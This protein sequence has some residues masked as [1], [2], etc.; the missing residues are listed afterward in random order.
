MNGNQ[1]D[2]QNVVVFVESSVINGKFIQGYDKKYDRI[3]SK[4]NDLDS[5]DHLPKSIIPPNS[6]VL[7]KISVFDGWNLYVKEIKVRFGK[8]LWEQV[9]ETMFWDKP[10]KTLSVKEWAAAISINLTLLTLFYIIATISLYLF[11][12]ITFIKWHEAV[13]N[14]KLPLPEKLPRFLFLFLIESSRSADA[15]V[16]YYLSKSL[17]LFYDNLETQTRK[18]WVPAPFRI[19]DK[20]IVSFSNNEL[21]YVP[22]LTEIKS[23]LNPS[24]IIISIE[25]PGGVGKSSFAF[26]IARWGFDSNPVKRI[27]KHKIIPLF[28]NKLSQN[29]DEAC[30]DKLQYI[31]N[32]T[33][34]SNSLYKSLLRNKRVLAVVDG[35]SE[36]NALSQDWI[37]AEKGAKEIQFV[38]YTSRKPLHFPESITIIPLGLKISYLDSLIDGFTNSYV[39]ANKFEDER[40][41]LRTRIKMIL[42]EIN[43]SDPDRPVPLVILRLMIQQ[44]SDLVDQGKHLS[45]ELPN[46]LSSLFENYISDLLRNTDSP[47][48]AERDLLKAAVVSMGLS[49]LFNKRKLL[50][51]ISLTLNHNGSPA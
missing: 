39:G 23:M 41:V 20:D 22:G 44:A 21:T 19:E 1:E 34:I 43:K 36:I 10:I 29:L 25:G 47:K 37:D 50:N 15:F 35:I 32:S 12:P 48:E 2:T 30:K 46:N 16:K 9:K 38:V 24:R 33:T 27:Q 11:S 7:F 31:M 4:F 14:S 51:P 42:S 8:T 17:N 49:E 18:F 3:S 13:S 45:D 26:Q 5:I 40:E 6:T 28:V